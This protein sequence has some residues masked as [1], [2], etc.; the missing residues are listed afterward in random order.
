MQARALPAHIRI[1]TRRSDLALWQANEVK[2]LLQAQLPDAYPIELVLIDSDG[3][4]QTETGFE[5]FGY[6]GVFTKR[7]EAALLDGRADMAVHSM[8]DVHSA[9]PDALLIAAM[10][11]RENP[12]DAF[13]SEKYSSLDAM[14]AGATIGT[15]SVRRAAVLRQLR[16]DLHIVPFRGNVPTRIAKL[17]RGEVDATFLAVA[18]LNRLGLAAHITHPM[19]LQRMLP[20]VAQGAIGIEC[21]REDANLL[22]LL[23]RINDTLTFQAVSA[24]RAMLARI[25]GD[26]HTPI[27]GYATI[28]DA[29]QTLS[30]SAEWILLKNGE[31]IATLRASG[32]AAV[33]DAIKIGEQVGEELLRQQKTLFA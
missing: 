30:L 13:V 3:D 26:C 18:G 32:N 12:Q 33:A 24:E 9:L 23:A 15:A 10:L 14:P 6:K 8:K 20:A 28:D 7:I 11:P 22:A 27:G 1:A 21:R 19:P 31:Y 25:D 5:K 16:P 17:Q 29:T 4:M 2:R